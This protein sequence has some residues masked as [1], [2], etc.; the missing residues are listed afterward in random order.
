MIKKLHVSAII[1]HHLV[2]NL[3]D[4]YDVKEPSD[5]GIE[6]VRGGGVAL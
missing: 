3:K 1:G 4:F 5:V 2:F 6:Q